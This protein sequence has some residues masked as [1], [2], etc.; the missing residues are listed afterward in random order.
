MLRS[1][2]WNSKTYRTENKIGFF[3][4]VGFKNGIT[5]LHVFMSN[6]YNARFQVF[7]SGDNVITRICSGTNAQPIRQTDPYQTI[8]FFISVFN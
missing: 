6:I 5:D 7:K 4:S 2:K 3:I 1:Y 8:R